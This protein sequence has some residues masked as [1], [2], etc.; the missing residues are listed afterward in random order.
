MY[1]Y[2]KLEKLHVRHFHNTVEIKTINKSFNSLTDN[3]IK[4]KSTSIKIHFFSNVLDMDEDVF[5]MSNLINL[6]EKT[7]KGIN[8]FICVSPYITD[9]KT[10]RVDSFKRHFENKY[11]TFNL[12]GEGIDMGKLGDTYWQCNHHFKGNTIHDS[13]HRYC[14][15]SNKWSKVIRVFS[16]IL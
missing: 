1:P 12:I 3:D 9:I 4:S 13:N 5:S 14:R 7:Q 16:V 15:G 8:Y 11:S 10:D 6:I 2:L